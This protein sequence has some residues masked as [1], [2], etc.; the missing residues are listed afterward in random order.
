MYRKVDLSMCRLMVA[1][2]IFAIIAATWIAPRT[3][4]GTTSAPNIHIFAAVFLGALVSGFPLLMYRLHPGEAVTRHVMAVSQI[5]W[6]ALLIH[7]TGGRIETHFHVFGSLAFLAFYRD[8]RV[9]I[10]ATVVVAADHMFRGIFWPQSV[11]G[12]TTSSNWRWIEHAGWVI[13]EDIVLVQSCVRG[14]LEMFSI[15][16]RQATIEAAKET[17]ELRRELWRK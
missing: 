5:L 13:F 17:T 3:W 10:T 11:F 12:V 4:I 7:L 8:W 2:W 16:R 1:Q 9:L 14:D 6:S 15:A